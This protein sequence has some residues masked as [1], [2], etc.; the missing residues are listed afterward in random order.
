MSLQT[1]FGLER[2]VDVTI[3]RKVPQV[4]YGTT[5]AIRFMNNIIGERSCVRVWA[6]RQ[7]LVH[8]PEAQLPVAY[9]LTQPLHTRTTGGENFIDMARWAGVQ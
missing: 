2:L 7:R 5:V 9:A 6:G 4:A 3:A 8:V 1:V